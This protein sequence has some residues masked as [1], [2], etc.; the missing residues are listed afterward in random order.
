MVSSQ[1]GMRKLSRFSA[2]SQISAIAFLDG[3]QSHR[4]GPGDDRVATISTRP[5][6]LWNNLRQLCLKAK[7]F[8]MSD[9][10]EI[11]HLLQLAVGA[12][13]NIPKLQVMEIWGS[14][15][16][17]IVH[18]FQY[19]VEQR[20]PTITWRCSEKQNLHLSRRII[21]HWI[22]VIDH[23]H[24]ELRSLEVIE[25]TF[26]ES[27]KEIQVSRGRFIHKHLALRRLIF[28]AVSFAQLEAEI[29]KAMRLH[30]LHYLKGTY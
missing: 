1:I 29:A 11:H 25:K 6:Y 2:T 26:E 19:K 13:P 4:F 3:L 28:D 7:A 10:K 30:R 27:V 21:D 8:S 15:P 16:N 22:G 14:S 24:P 9:T 5:R 23:V 18:L 12:V 17:G 20:Q